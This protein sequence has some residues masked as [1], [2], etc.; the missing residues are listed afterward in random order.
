MRRG[1]PAQLQSTT[2]FGYPEQILRVLNWL[3]F[4]FVI[5]AAIIGSPFL[6]RRSAVRRVR[7]VGT[8]DS[9]SRQISRNLNPA[10]RI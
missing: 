1:F 3:L 6:T 8:I 4:A 9:S 10:Q 5:M 7:S 2:V